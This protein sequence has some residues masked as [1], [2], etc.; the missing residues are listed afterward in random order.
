MLQ[1]TK[2]DSFFTANNQSMPLSISE[3]HIACVAPKQKDFKGRTNGQSGMGVR[4]KEKK[5]KN[6]RMCKSV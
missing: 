1:K 4:L 6:K 3:G 2:A 5:Q